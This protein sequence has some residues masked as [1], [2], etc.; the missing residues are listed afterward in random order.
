MGMA[1]TQNLF[2]SLKNI[3]AQTFGLYGMIDRVKTLGGKIEI[4][5]D[6]ENGTEIKIQ[7]Q[8]KIK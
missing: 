8:R 6:K 5:S 7:L 2:L 4:N 1:L 3:R